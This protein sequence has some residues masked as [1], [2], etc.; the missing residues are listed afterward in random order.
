[1]ARLMT[2]AYG[3]VSYLFFLAVFVYSIGFVGDIAVPRSVDHG[4][5]APIGAAFVVNVVLL[6]LFAAQHSVMARPAF[7]RWWTRFVP[8]PIE[9]STYVLL[10]SLVLALLFW[11]WRTIPAVIWHVGWQPGRAALWV[12][13]AAGWV[14]VLLST[15]MINHFDL[16]GLRQVYLAWRGT[17]YTRLGFR[18]SM[19]YRVVRHPIMA[20]FIVAFWA[21]PDM[22]AGHLLFAVATT[23]YIL[24]AIQF[25]E[26]D[27]AADLGEQYRGY[28]DRV[29]MLV[30]GMHHR[31]GPPRGN[32]T[33]PG[34]LPKPV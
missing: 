20:G 19:L 10:A 28:R 2:I 1:M 13:F 26:H 34:S 6:G 33:F 22:T 3:V 9:R 29:P 17:P 12:V 8:A 31:A 11:Q 5:S 7:K 27:L 18:T 23:A 24:A 30:P 16:F 25:E 21:T 4:I 32:P 14:T 15:F